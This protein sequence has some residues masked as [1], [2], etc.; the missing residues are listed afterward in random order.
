MVAG[1]SQA[2]A[3]RSIGGS[4]GPPPALFERL[5][6]D[7]AVG[8]D[9][10][11]LEPQGHRRAGVHRGQL[12]WL[13]AKGRSRVR[14]DERPHD[15]TVLAPGCGANHID[16]STGGASARVRTAPWCWIQTKAVVRQ[17]EVMISSAVPGR[18]S[19]CS[20]RSLSARARASGS[21]VTATRTS[22]AAGSYAGRGLAGVRARRRRGRT[23]ACAGRSGNSGLAS[24][25]S[26]SASQ[27]VMAPTSGMTSR[28]ATIPMFTV[29]L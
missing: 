29:P 26:S 15:L 6:R 21:S 19:P 4:P 1:Q 18:R 8:R 5:N 23:G 22:G 13:G 27:L 24:A 25:S 20:R 12:E 9:G 28:S 14:I 11:V 3:S 10:V 2:Q 17:P 16:A 7:H